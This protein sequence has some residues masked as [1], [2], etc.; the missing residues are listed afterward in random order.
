MIL[1]T[2]S[3]TTLEKSLTKIKAP[4]TAVAGKKN[5]GD[6]IT[7]DGISQDRYVMLAIAYSTV[8]REQAM[9]IF[10]KYVQA[11]QN[12][13]SVEQVS[14]RN[15]S[16]RL[17]FSTLLSHSTQ[18]ERFRIY[19]VEKEFYDLFPNTKFRFEVI[20]REGY[21]LYAVEDKDAEDDFIEVEE[22]DTYV[23]GDT[24]V[25][26]IRLLPDDDYGQTT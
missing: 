14:V 10:E 24:H 25:K 26:I 9:K 16:G 20:D 2:I 23:D 17:C 6:R 4:A 8:L 3:D 22:G 21:P 11:V 5:F 12:I 19:G 13:P 15:D 7:S 18:E 1:E